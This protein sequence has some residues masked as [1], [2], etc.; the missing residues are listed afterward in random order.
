[1]TAA[2]VRLLR[3]LWHSDSGHPVQGELR[4]I[5]DGERGMLLC[6]GCDATFLVKAD[7]PIMLPATQ[8]SPAERRQLREARTRLLDRRP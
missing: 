4:F 7:I 3:C 2:A 1:M 6:V 8:L 5:G